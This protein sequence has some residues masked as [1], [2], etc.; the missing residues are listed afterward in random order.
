MCH[1]DAEDGDIG[2]LYELQSLVEG[3]MAESIEPGTH[4]ENSLLA[5]HVFHFVEC[6]DEGVEQVSF[7]E[8]GEIELVNGLLDFL[9]I[10]SEV[11]FQVRLHVESLE[12]QPI[13]FFQVADEIGGP[14]FSSVGK[15]RIAQLAEFHQH[16]DGDGSIG[17]R[18]IG[19][20]LRFAVFRDAEIFFFQAR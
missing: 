18:E 4:Q 10:L 20:L 5:F 17:G 3:M 13:F 1:A 14:V 15:D 2:L 16:D 19:D 8:T 12:R 11:H 9:F 6:L 7:P